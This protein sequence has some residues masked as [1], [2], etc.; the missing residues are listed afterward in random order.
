M[1]KALKKRRLSLVQSLQIKITTLG[2]WCTAE[3]IRFSPK[4]WKIPNWDTKL[5]GG[6]QFERMLAEFRTVSDR[7]VLSELSMDDI[8]TSAGLS[9]LKSVPNHIWAVF[10]MSVTLIV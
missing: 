9:G 1:D 5:Y 8:A 10:I 4:D 7:I 6:Q 3:T 2:E